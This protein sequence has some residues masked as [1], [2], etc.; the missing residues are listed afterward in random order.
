M[1][2]FA[3]DLREAGGLSSP[4]MGVQISGH[5]APRQLRILPN[6]PGPRYE[7]DAIPGRL[8]NT[9]ARLCALSDFPN[10]NRRKVD[11]TIQAP[12]Q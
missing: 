12:A 3:R 4:K 6:A 11:A 9:P 2:P 8:Q 10:P 7:D 5:F 1:S